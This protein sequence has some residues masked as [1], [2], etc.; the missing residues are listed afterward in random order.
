MPRYNLN[1]QD[2]ETISTALDKLL[3]ECHNTQ[4]YN[5]VNNLKSRLLIKLTNKE[6]DPD[7]N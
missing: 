4:E 7:V 3:K 5:R 1:H 6:E 2:V